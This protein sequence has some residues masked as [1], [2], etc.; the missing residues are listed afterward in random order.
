[1]KTIL[2]TLLWS[3]TAFLSPV[4]AT[5][6]TTGPKQRILIS[7]PFSFRVAARSSFK[8]DH[9]GITTRAAHIPAGI[10][11]YEIG[12][13]ITFKTTKR[14]NL[15]WKHQFV[16]FQRY[17]SFPSHR[18]YSY[19]NATRKIYSRVDLY[20]NAKDKPTTVT[21]RFHGRT[22]PGGDYF[23]VVYLLE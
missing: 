9:N 3:A 2:V 16:S 8:T 15:T 13:T 1:M 18:Y 11:R 12:K 17:V 19:E 7:E 4:S 10:P 22:K 5:E 14:G 23:H 20:V 6:V 21:V